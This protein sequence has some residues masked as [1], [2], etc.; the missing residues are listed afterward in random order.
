MRFII[1]GAGGVGCVVGAEL[2]KAGVEVV[3]IARGAHLEALQSKGLRYETPSEDVVLR[4]EA[5]GHPAEI[6][7]RDDD[8]VMLTMKTQHTEAALAE[9]LA[10][11]GPDIPVICCQNGVANER[12]AAR[13]FRQVYGMCVYLP[14]QFTEP[15]RVQCH[16]QP[17]RGILDLGLYPR[18]TDER[19]VEIGRHLERGAISARPVAEVMRLKYAKLLTNLGNALGAVAPREGAAGEI[20]A[21]LRE[22]GRACLKAASIDWAGDDEVRARRQGVVE[23][24]AIGGITRVGGSSIQSL[25]RGTGDIETDYLN[26][27]IVDLGRRHGVP[28]PANAVVQRLANDLAARRAPPGSMAIDEVQRQIADAA[29]GRS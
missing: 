21:M 2:H 26:G 18:G 9:L 16:G 13:E 19:A 11:R 10:L 15:G 25:L 22:E 14:A 17:M 29:E 12:F 3:L 1:Y 4:I 27:E 8:V 6:A 28:T 23:H 20:L 7:L 24:G 5:V